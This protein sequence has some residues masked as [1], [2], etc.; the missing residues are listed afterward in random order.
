MYPVPTTTFYQ[1]HFVG[2]RRASP[3]LPIF[4]NQLVGE[5]GFTGQVFYFHLIFSGKTYRF[6]L[7]SGQIQGSGDILTDGT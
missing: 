2:V 4:T 7:T 3:T 1:R 6:F 5:L